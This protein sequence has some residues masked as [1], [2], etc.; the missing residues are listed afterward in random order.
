MA[1]TKMARNRKLK[2]KKFNNL[3]WLE[4]Q[5]ILDNE[6]HKVSLEYINEFSKEIN[7]GQTTTSNTNI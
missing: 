4:Q 7:H 3:P 2:Q 6:K 1:S 5:R